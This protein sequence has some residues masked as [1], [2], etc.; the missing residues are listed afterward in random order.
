M[1]RNLD[2][3]AAFGRKFFA[4]SGMA[5]LLITATPTTTARRT[6]TR[7]QRTTVTRITMLVTMH[8]RLRRPRLTLT[9]S[10][11]PRDRATF[12]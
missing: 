12:G 8:R 6:I 3:D 10:R 4:G 5:D 2:R 1:K 11:R 9:R 7:H